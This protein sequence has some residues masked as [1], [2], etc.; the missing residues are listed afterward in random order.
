MKKFIPALA[1]GAALTLALCSCQHLTPIDEQQAAVGSLSR[2]TP[3]EKN[4]L[5][6]SWYEDISLPK[7]EEAGDDCCCI[8]LQHN[9]YNL[10]IAV[11]ECDYK[12]SNPAG[13]RRIIDE[14]LKIADSSTN[15]D[16][17]T[18]DLKNGSATEEVLNIRKTAINSLILLNDPEIFSDLE[19]C[20][21][22]SAYSDPVQEVIIE[23]LIKYLPQYATP[24]VK[25]GLLRKALLLKAGR[26]PSGTPEGL[27]TLVG[28]CD[29]LASLNRALDDAR[30][31][32]KLLEQL[33]SLNL[34]CW[35]KRIAENADFP[36]KE[37][38]EN[39]ALL[40][41]FALSPQTGRI[42][43]LIYYTLCEIVPGESLNVFNTRFRQD[44]TFENFDRMLSFYYALRKSAA[45]GRNSPRLDRLSDFGETEAVTRKLAGTFL[46][47]KQKELPP[48]QLVKAY[49]LLAATF[50]ELLCARLEENFRECDGSPAFLDAAVNTALWM[51]DQRTVSGKNAAEL[52]ESIDGL[53]FSARTRPDYKTVFGSVMANRED[54]AALRR[55]ML[56]AA[57]S[58]E[59]AA[60]GDFIDCLFSVLEKQ[61]KASPGKTDPQYDA[62]NL[63]ALDRLLSSLDG[64]TVLKIA[65]YLERKGQPVFLVDRLYAHCLARKKTPPPFAYVV[66]AG[67]TGSRNR[68]LLAG[69]PELNK[70]LLRFFR[71]GIANSDDALSLLCAD[72]YFR[73]AAAGSERDAALADFSARWP[74]L[75]KLNR[76]KKEQDAK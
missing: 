51:I 71:D 18:A 16:F 70:A 50:P 23:G 54:C 76:V 49:E 28:R 32:P 68:K 8:R 56:S 12:K 60:K 43:N 11:R 30:K 61:E 66:I 27:E 1:V 10:A 72:Y 13:Y 33:L 75:R 21:A 53:L 38:R 74:G 34:N 57:A 7:L 6:A 17:T 73:L 9:L 58:G 20:F 59:I 48:E 65:A 15:L 62:D 19:K 69:N 29:D 42:D 2:C 41:H 24:G 22:D 47:T 52:A 40:K 3:Q 26:S 46:E 37:A 25:A 64:R 63:K 45:V 44:G 5:I 67:E 14:Y 35:R 39:I 4:E 55:I 31:N 36:E